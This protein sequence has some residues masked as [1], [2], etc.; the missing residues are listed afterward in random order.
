SSGGPIID[1]AGNLVGLVSSTAPVLYTDT[2][3]AKGTTTGQGNLQ[4]VRHNCVTGRAILDLTRPPA[5]PAG[6]K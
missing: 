5:K 4:M 1:Q 3:A 6:A 2:A